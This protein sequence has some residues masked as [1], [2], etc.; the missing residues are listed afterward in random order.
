MSHEVLNRGLV[1]PKPMGSHLKLTIMVFS[2]KK[3]EKEA[4]KIM[5][6]RLKPTEDSSGRAN[7]NKQFLHLKK[8][9]SQMEEKSA[10]SSKR[11]L[12]YQIF[13]KEPSIRVLGDISNDGKVECTPRNPLSSTQQNSSLKPSITVTHTR[14]PSMNFL[15][16]QSKSIMLHPRR[17]LM[18]SS[19]HIEETSKKDPKTQLPTPSPTQQKRKSVRRPRVFAEH[20]EGLKAVGDSKQLQAAEVDIVNRLVINGGYDL[21]EK[22]KMLDTVV[23]F[24]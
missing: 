6:D 5:K 3:S 24:D 21:K 17:N 14:N 16:P 19:Q 13:T 18:K 15:D 10:T 12:P 7:R 1:G 4:E 11:F 9:D 8:S 23:A 2:C 20:L 22:V